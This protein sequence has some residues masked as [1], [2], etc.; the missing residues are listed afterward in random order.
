[1]LAK[2]RD[3]THNPARYWAVGQLHGSYPETAST[4]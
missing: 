4:K 1:L 2:N 3:S